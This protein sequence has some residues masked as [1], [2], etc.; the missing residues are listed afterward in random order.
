LK[1]YQFN[2]EILFPLLSHRFH[3]KT[4]SSTTSMNL[5]FVFGVFLLL[6]V[7]GFQ[8]FPRSY[9]QAGAMNNTNSSEK[10]W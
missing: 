2:F 1:L 7:T 10:T 9:K 3:Y 8:G 5:I 6:A 4:E